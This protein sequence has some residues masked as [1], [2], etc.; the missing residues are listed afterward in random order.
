MRARMEQVVE[1]IS[2]YDLVAGSPAARRLLEGVLENLGRLAMRLRARGSP[3][4]AGRAERLACRVRLTLRDPH[5]TWRM[6]ALT[7]GLYDAPSA[8]VLC[9]RAL[10]GAISLVGSDFG[11][12]QTADEATGGL[13]I[14]AQSGFSSEFLEY[15]AVVRAGDTSGCG[16]AAGCGA[17]SVIADVEADAAFAPH[18]EIAVA[19]GVR[20]VQST[21]LVELTGQVGGVISTHF[22][23][24]Y[25]PARRECEIVQWYADHSAAAL[26]HPQSSSVEWYAEAAASG[27]G[28][29]NVHDAAALVLCENSGLLLPTGTRRR[30]SR[31]AHWRTADTPRSSSRGRAPHCRDHPH[32]SSRPQTAR[33]RAIAGAGTGG[34]P[35]R[36]QAVY[37]L[38][39]FEHTTDAVLACDSDWRITVWNRAAEGMFGWT[40]EEAVGRLVDTLISP[41]LAEEGIGAPSDPEAW[42]QATTWY[43]RHGQAVVAEHR[44]VALAGDAQESGYAFLMREPAEVRQAEARSEIAA[45]Q[46]AL[47]VALGRR[48]LDTTLPQL[49][50]STTTL[51]PGLLGLDLSYVDKVR[52]CDTPGGRF[53]A[54]A[55]ESDL[56]HG[57]ALRGMRSAAAVVIPTPRGPFGALIVAARQA[58]AFQ[59]QEVDFLQSVANILGFAVERAE[60][61]DA[62][63]AA[64]QAERSRIARDLHDDVLYE[65]SE[66]L[67]RATLGSARPR[68]EDAEQY[69][70]EQTA[71]LQRLGRQIRGAV[72]DLSLDTHEDHPFADLLDALIAIQDGLAG[73]C[74]VELGGRDRVP[75]TPLGRRGTQVLRIVREAITNARRHSGA[76]VIRVNAS[77]STPRFLQL[78]V[79]DNGQWLDRKGPLTGRGG[80]GIPSMLDRAERLHGTLQI[81]RR[82]DGGTRASLRLPLPGL[83]RPVE[84]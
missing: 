74:R 40:T 55:G 25:R 66:A 27:A 28:M 82:P 51:V 61:A 35:E 75:A 63:E 17:Q 50:E 60:T 80:T 21:P 38:R 54:A 5:A 8:A 42:R 47:L 14:A 76:T 20:S 3:A 77:A 57:L 62:L 64:R 34:V 53:E 52:G 48:A 2:G 45:R 29:P 30:R 68:Q 26:A 56:P 84:S 12:L 37:L 39:L 11:T 16:R 15:F 13:I 43:G 81:E 9:E 72:Y 49:L 23:Q 1:A 19:S 71:S 78:D 7:R 36:E 70:A 69:W 24:P 65:L 33:L 79:N 59:P 6:Q 22:A 41:R 67:A 32:R 18:R 31:D 10:E 73:D 58:H 44:S 46:Q 4:E 83:S